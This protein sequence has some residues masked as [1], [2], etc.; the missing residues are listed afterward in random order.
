[1]SYPE[2]KARFEDIFALRQYYFMREL[3]LNN[4]CE[5]PKN[6]NSV[7][8]CVTHVSRLNISHVD[9]TPALPKS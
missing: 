7:Q 9:R 8:N 1:M 3:E 2:Q 5:K 4:L 6:N